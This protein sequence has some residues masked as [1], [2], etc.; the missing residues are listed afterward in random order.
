M[1]IKYNCEARTLRE[2]VEMLMKIRDEL[3]NVTLDQIVDSASI[4]VHIES[5]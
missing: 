5:F 1:T 4:L 2:A 3:G